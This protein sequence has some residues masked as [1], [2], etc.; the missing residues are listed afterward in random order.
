MTDSLV[1]LSIDIYALSDHPDNTEKYQLAVSMKNSG[2][3][4]FG[5]QYRTKKEAE[6]FLRKIK[7]RQLFG[8]DEG[9]A[10]MQL[11]AEKTRLEL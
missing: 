3:V 5:R 1:L 7:K 8:F 9:F 6:K 10:L 2:A 4:T 11:V